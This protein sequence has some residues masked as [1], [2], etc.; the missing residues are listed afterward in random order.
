M[1]P[2]TVK[3]VVMTLSLDTPVGGGGCVAHEFK[4]AQTIGTDLV[5][6]RNT[7]TPYGA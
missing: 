3:A 2:H 7:S 1:T 5:Q 6:N 4:L